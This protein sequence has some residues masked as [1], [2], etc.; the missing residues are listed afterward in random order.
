MMMFPTKAD[1]LQEKE[2]VVEK[3]SITRAA[4]PQITSAEDQAKPAEE[5][6]SG[7]KMGRRVEGIGARSSVPGL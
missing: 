1:S 2:E 6:L 3:T 5:S 7:N 4:A